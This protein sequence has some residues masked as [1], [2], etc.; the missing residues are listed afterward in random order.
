M[1]DG[2]LYLSTPFGRVIALDPETGTAALDV[3]RARRPQRQLGRLRQSRR[4]HMA[5][6]ARAARPRPVAAESTSARSTRASSR[7][8][9]ELERPVAASAT[10][11]TV[12]LA[13]WPAQLRRTTTAEYQLTSPPAVINGTDRHRLVGRRQQPHQRGERRSARVRRAHR[14]AAVGVGIPFRATRP[15]RR[16][17]VGA[18]RWRTPPARPTRG[19]SSPPTR[20][21]ISCSFPPAAPVPTTTAASASATTATRTRSSRCARRRE[22]SSGIFR[23]CI[24]ICGTTTTRRRPRSSRSRTT[25]AASTS[26]CRRRRPASSSCSI[27]TPASRFSRSRSGRFRRAPSS[28]NAHRRRSR[29]TRCIPPLSPQRFSLDSVWGADAGRSRRVSR[30]DSAAAQRGPVHAAELSGN[31][32]GAVE[33]RR[34][35][36]GRPGVRSAR[37]IA[38]IPVNTHRG[39]RPAHPPRRARHRRRRRRNSHRGSAISTRACT[40]RRT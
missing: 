25:A 31:V 24:T 5:R 1:V 7:S 15:I 26:C 38:I 29:S 6:P 13:A 37:Q 2:T 18:A 14:R 33:R 9:R 23:R 22:R 36:L 30:A 16:G 28:A 12:D 40:A 3:R 10:T 32:G 11:G 20:R 34:R 27:A 17:T 8:T 21:V 35:A 4:V 39:V 19:R